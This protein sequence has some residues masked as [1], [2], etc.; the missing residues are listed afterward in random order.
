MTAVIKYGGNAMINS[1]LML[2]V[3]E[4][5]SDLHD[6]GLRVVLVHG[7]GPDIEK[8]L[9]ATGIKSRFVHG[10]RYTD[11]DTMDVV[12]MV[13]CGKTNKNICAMFNT[14]GGKAV[15]ISG[16]DGALLEATRIPELG[17]VGEIVR[18]NTRL[19]DT[20]LNSDMIPVISPV[21]LGTGDAKG[22][23]L[24]INAD[25]AAAAVAAALL[26]DELVLVTDIPG[27]LRDVSDPKSLIR[28]VSTEEIEELKASG[29]ISGGM[30][31]K[32][33]GCILA[34]KNG[35]KTI[36]IVDGRMP[37]VLKNSFNAEGCSCGT[38]IKP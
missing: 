22:K 7:G 8:T 34:I 24:N 5:I 33:D 37:H 21:A 31:P 10:L 11:E 16:I 4:D 3:T 36:R 12:R 35:V 20:L 32:I 17:F 14:H 19:L 1:D 13:L 29:V 2:A 23:A 28:S 26:A 25:T 15:G 18:V 27:L 6:N 38:L 9:A 30:V